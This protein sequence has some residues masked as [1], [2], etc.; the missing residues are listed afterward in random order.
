MSGGSGP[1]RTPYQ[2]TRGS[3]RYDLIREL[4]VTILLEDLRSAFNVGSFF[5]TA[6]AVKASMLILA[7]I[8]ATPPH[9]GVLKTALGAENT[10]RWEYAIDAASA[11]GSLRDSGF[12]TAVIETSP[13]AV[14]LFDWVPRF[15][16][17]I[18]FGNELEGVSEAAAAACDVHIRIPMLGMKHS[19]NVATS[20]GVVLYELLR[21][22]R[23]LL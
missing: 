14:D 21:K 5:R 13:H 7:G 3:E 23:Q 22:Y 12:E 1:D 11:I 2:V 18:V 15:P 8:T 6:D 10:V 16:L 20:G 19:L 4:P 17:C 9:T